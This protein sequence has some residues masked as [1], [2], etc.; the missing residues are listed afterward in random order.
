MKSKQQITLNFTLTK[1]ALVIQTAPELIIRE[2]LFC[3]LNIFQQV[4]RQEQIHWHG[5]SEVL[6]LYKNALLTM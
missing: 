3:K 6:H 5:G 2:S 1:Y 4:S